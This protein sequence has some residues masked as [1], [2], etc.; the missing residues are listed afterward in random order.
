MRKPKP[1]FNHANDRS[2][3]DNGKSK[4]NCKLIITSPSNDPKD[5]LSA[6]ANL[7]SSKCIL[8]T[9]ITGTA[10]GKA[11]LL[12]LS[13][14]DDTRKL[15]EDF[16]EQNKKTTFEISIEKAVLKTKSF[17]RSSKPVYISTKSNTSFLEKIKWAYQYGFPNQIFIP[18]SN[19][20]SNNEC[21]F[22]KFSRDEEA[23]QAVAD[24]RESNFNANFANPRTYPRP[25]A[26]TEK[27]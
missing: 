9:K 18:A 4:G 10:R 5:L 3:R 11:G 15:K 22:V 23:C 14:K 20:Y 8:E 26:K 21:F 2:M 1:T 13:S 12:I 6:T 25:S 7:P 16:T 17:P 19:K 27:N 24:H